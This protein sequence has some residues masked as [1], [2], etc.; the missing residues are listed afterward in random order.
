MALTTD[1]RFKP[2]SIVIPLMVMTPFLYMFTSASLLRTWLSSNNPTYSHGLLLLVIS[3]FI[4]F[5]RWTKFAHSIQ[6]KPNAPGIVLL[7]LTSL[8]WLLAY[9]GNVL[10]VQQLALV[11]LLLFLLWAT[12]GYGTARALAFPILI[13]FF[14]I[15][16]WEF[17]NP[18]LQDFVATSVTF[19]LGVVGIP[20]VLEGIFILVPAGTFEV[21]PDCS[22]LSQLL[23][24]MMLT[25]LFVYDRQV[26]PRPAIILLG[27][28]VL[29]AFAMNM[30]RIFTVVLAGQLTDMQ[31]YLI[32]T[33][34]WIFGWVLFAVGMVIFLFLA[35][36]YVHAG[37]RAQNQAKPQTPERR[38]PTR[39]NNTSVLA[40]PVVLLTVAGL[41]SGPALAIFTIR[42][43][44]TWSM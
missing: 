1:L 34:H 29:V 41:V 19:W 5:R 14:A 13:M 40:V 22:G 37:D 43:C 26:K 12:I 16:L 18:Y 42:M 28:A 11:C 4:F 32:T 33:D 30:I 8:V 6:F 39:A 17:L 3:I 9:I 10:V 31:H 20:A 25:L 44:Q 38:V 15:P 35:D 36:R 27:W 7:T 24:S 23:V 2:A 21:S